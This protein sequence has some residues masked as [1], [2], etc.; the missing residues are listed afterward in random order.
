VS[1]DTKR[2]G[3]SFDVITVTAGGGVIWRDYDHP[4][5]PVTTHGDELPQDVRDRRD[6]EQKESGE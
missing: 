4:G 5:R 1:T 2:Q 6:K 3:N